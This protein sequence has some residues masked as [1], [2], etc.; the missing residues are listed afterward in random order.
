MPHSHCSLSIMTLFL[1][2][3]AT[4]LAGSTAQTSSAQDEA[5][6]TVQIFVRANET[7]NLDLMLSTFDEDATVFL[8]NGVDLA[9][10]PHFRKGTAQERLRSALQ[11]A[12]GPNHDHRPRRDGPSLHGRRDHH[13]ALE[14]LADGTGTGARSLFLVAHLCFAVPEIAG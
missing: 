6:A 11:I 10:V 9:P 8:P 14:R 12:D 4:A 7:A 5:M 13:L 2:L 1:I 3:I